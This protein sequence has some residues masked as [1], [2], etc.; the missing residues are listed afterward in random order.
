MLVMLDTIA[1]GVVVVVFLYA[2]LVAT[3]QWAI[4]R[5]RLTPFGA[6]PRF[7]RRISEP[8]LLPLERRIIRAGGSPNDA[9]LWL[10]G[11]AI[12]GGL[13]LITLVRWLIGAVYE[14]GVL[15]Q[16]PP[17]I[18]LI[19]AVS[20]LFQ[21]SDDRA[22]GEGDRLLVGRFPLQQV[23]PTLCRAHRLAARAAP[24]SVAA[25]GTAR[26]QPDGRL[27]PSVDR[28]AGARSRPPLSPLAAA[29]DGVRLRV[30]VQPR[31]SRSELMGVRGD[32]LKVRVAAP[33]MDGAANE[34]LVRLLADR[35]G[36]APSSVTIR[37]GAWSRS[38]TV[39]VSGVTLEHA[40]RQLGL[41]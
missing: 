19:E 36:V 38:K 1:R 39:V 5:R 15:T 17:R 14:V 24:S 23:D 10:L 3:T 20:W 33:P 31:A 21:D 40:A 35:I 13:L 18:W 25:H 6:W 2:V 27:L 37:G 12:V 11:I 16:A 9:P 30:R 4:R 7:V 32:E 28:P 29:S 22:A 34:A 8:V 41:E 26:S